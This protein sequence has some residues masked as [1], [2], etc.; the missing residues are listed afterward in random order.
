[1]A[2]AAQ[3]YWNKALNELTLAEAAYLATLPS[4]EQLRCLQA[5]RA[6]HRAAQLGDRPYR[7]ER[8]RHT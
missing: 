7:R 4:A 5:H 2:A 1:M 8:L 6:R 3:T